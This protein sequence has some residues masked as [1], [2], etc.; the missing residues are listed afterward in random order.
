MS[1]GPP[2]PPPSSTDPYRS[3]SPYPFDRYLENGACVTLTDIY[4]ARFDDYTGAPKG[5]VYPFNETT[6]QIAVDVTGSWYLE[7]SLFVTQGSRLVIQGE[8][9]LESRRAEEAGMWW[10]KRTIGLLEVCKR[11]FVHLRARVDVCR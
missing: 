10:H 1:H 5:P 2:S 4:E 3:I 11:E 8:A 7:S 9:T 6:Q